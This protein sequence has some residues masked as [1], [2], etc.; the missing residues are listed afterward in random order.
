VC[1]NGEGFE[2]CAF[3][4][5]YTA[6]NGCFVIHVSG[7]HINPIFKGPVIQQFLFGLPSSRSAINKI[8]YDTL[9]MWNLKTI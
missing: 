5:F 8:H 7:Q 9:H 1:V 6:E 2:I 3:W 4:G